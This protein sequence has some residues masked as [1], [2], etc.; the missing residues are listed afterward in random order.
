MPL[1]KASRR[2][3]T[4]ERFELYRLL[5]RWV[6]SWHWFC[7]CSGRGVVS[8]LTR[9]RYSEAQQLGDQRRR[10]SRDRVPSLDLLLSERPQYSHLHT[11]LRTIITAASPIPVKVILEKVFKLYW[12][13]SS[14]T[15]RPLSLPQKQGPLSW[16]SAGDTKVDISITVSDGTGPEADTLTTA[17]IL[18]SKV[19]SLSL[20]SGITSTSSRLRRV[21]I[22]RCPA[23]GS[24]W[25]YCMNVDTWRVLSLGMS[26]NLF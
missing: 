13:R 5:Y 17:I 16:R 11:H 18:A 24:R 19:I 6:S 21:I 4:P 2:L 10:E 9:A 22:K 14:I 12:H 3:R 15:L 20:A 7:Q 23:F 8:Y 25:Q 1:C 26:D